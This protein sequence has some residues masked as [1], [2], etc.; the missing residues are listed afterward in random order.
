MSPQLIIKEEA[1]SDI[2]DAYLWYENRNSGLGERFLKELDFSFE[3]ILRHPE[4]YQKQYRSFRQCVLS[5]F[6]YVIIYEIEVATIVVYSVFH[7]SRNPNS[8]PG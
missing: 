8:K 7:T 3:Q 4:G 2:T 5:V 6:P 1:Q